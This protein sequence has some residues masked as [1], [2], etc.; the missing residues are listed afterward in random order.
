MYVKQGQQCEVRTSAGRAIAQAVSHRLLAAEARIRAQGIPCGI[1]D[2]QSGK[3]AGFSQ[4]P[5]FS[6]VNILPSLLHICSYIIWGMDKGPVGD[7][8]SQRPNSIP[9]QQ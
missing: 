2:R 1:C 9:S 7:P 5:S 8:V 3:G 6:P 4:S